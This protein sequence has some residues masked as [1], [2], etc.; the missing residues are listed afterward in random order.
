MKSQDACALRHAME[1][2]IPDRTRG[3]LE[4]RAP[5]CYGRATV[6]KQSQE[7][8]A[9][10]EKKI[11]RAE[12]IWILALLAL[13]LLPQLVGPVKTK[14]KE[15]VEKWA[16]IDDLNGKTFVSI[17]G[18]DFNRLI[19]ERFPDSRIIYVQDWAD[20]DISIIQGKA[21]AEVCEQSSAKEII[22][23]YPDLCIMPEAIGRLDSRW[24]TSKTSFGNRVA[25]EFNTYLAMLRKDGTL[26]RIYETWEDPDNAP[27]HVDMPAMT[28]EPK[29]KLT[30]V[31]SLDWIPMC[32]RKGDQACG[33]FIDLCYRFCAWAGYEPDF[34]YVNI[35]SALAGFNS[36]KYDLLAYGTEYREEATDRMNFTDT[37][38]DEPIYVMIRKDHYAYAEADPADNDLEEKSKASVFFS[39]L[40]KSFIRNFITEDRWK[41]LLRGLGV[42]A[43]LSVLTTIFGTLL[44]ILICA[45]RMSG[46]TY[47]TAFAR[48]YIKTV[49]GI[50]I[51]V[52]LMI[53]YYLIFANSPVTAFWACVIG[54]SIDF[55]AYTAEIFRSGIEA[56]PPGQER[57]ARALGFSK[58]SAFLQVVAPQALIYIIPVY[59]GELIAMVKQTSVAGYISVEDLTRASDIIRSRTYEAF[60]PLVLTAIIY[61]LL[62]WL[63][64]QILKILKK[65]LD[66][67]VRSRKV[68][69]VNEHADRG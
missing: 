5:A 9:N 18:S 58:S 54:F 33:F 48:I 31:T 37:I 36:G 55:S 44:G 4:R 57:A 67:S 38:Y 19:N 40:K 3:T 1:K 62:A 66:P 46:H 53:L 42:T 60:F 17:P 63:L 8:T 50:P 69:G 25:K 61:F 14:D 13:I 6:M 68:K 26:D 29:G 52:L 34:E 47:I 35:E 65:R 56:V 2:C 20:Q 30:I 59:M 23:T 43:A 7:K 28:G 51:L 22:K 41:L 32:Y 11:F 21:D 49:Q 39:N 45:M 10:K 27:D 16:Q 15:D 12:I 64:T 24:C